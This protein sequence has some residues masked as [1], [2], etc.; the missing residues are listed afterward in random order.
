MTMGTK[1]RDTDTQLQL[2]RHSQVQEC[3]KPHH[4]KRIA[5]AQKSIEEKELET[6]HSDQLNSGKN[7][8][9]N[10]FASHCSGNELYKS[11]QQV[12]MSKMQL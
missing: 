6:L 2:K 12:L 10:A 7:V 11:R 4:Y 1:L 5:L 3:N 9:A 8:K